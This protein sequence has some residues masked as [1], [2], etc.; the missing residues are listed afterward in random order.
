MTEYFGNKSATPQVS[1][2]KFSSVTCAFSH[3]ARTTASC[4]ASDHLNV[5][6][7]SKFVEFADLFV[8]DG[9]FMA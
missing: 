1:V 6:F 7:W 4:C 3:A 5:F 2:F 9:A 8:H